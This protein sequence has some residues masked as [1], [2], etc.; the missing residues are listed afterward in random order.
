MNLIIVSLLYFKFSKSVCV[1]KYVS[2]K[3][4]LHEIYMAKSPL[5]FRFIQPIVFRLGKKIMF[6]EKKKRSKSLIQLT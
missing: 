2:L 6:Q 5:I 1:Y 3:L 4:S